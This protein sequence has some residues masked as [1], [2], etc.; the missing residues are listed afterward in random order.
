MRSPNGTTGMASVLVVILTF[1][2]KVRLLTI[3]MNIYLGGEY[4]NM[5]FNIIK[6][7]PVLTAMASLWLLVILTAIAIQNGVL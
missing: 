5:R 6:H 3:H 7:L 1:P 4:L 2:H